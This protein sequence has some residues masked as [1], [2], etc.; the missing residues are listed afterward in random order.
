MCQCMWCEEATG[1]AN[2]RHHMLPSC[3]IKGLREQS[4]ILRDMA[5]DVSEFKTGKRASPETD[6]LRLVPT[7]NSLRAMVPNIRVQEWK[8][9][10]LFLKLTD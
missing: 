9:R 5:C 4:I 8:K 3:H 2:K 10:S 6:K 7:S 1:N